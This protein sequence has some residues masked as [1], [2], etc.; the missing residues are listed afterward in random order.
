MQINENLLVGRVNKVTTSIV[1]IESTNENAVQRNLIDGEIFHGTN[2]GEYVIIVSPGAKYLAE[3]T[4]ASIDN[5]EN[6]KVTSH[7]R[8]AVGYDN[9]TNEFFVGKMPTIGGKVYLATSDEIQIFTSRGL[10]IDNNIRQT[11]KPIDKVLYVGN[12]AD[13]IEVSV[14]PSQLFNRHMLLMGATGSGKSTTAVTILSKLE[15]FDSTSRVVIIDPT[16]EY[17]E[18][19]ENQ[20][21]FETFTLGRDAVL[22]Q[23][24]TSPN[25]IADL[26]QAA[27]A[28]QRPLLLSAIESLKIVHEKIGGNPNFAE[29]DI[30][31]DNGLLIKRNHNR[32]EYDYA[33]TKLHNLERDNGTNVKWEFGKLAAQLMEETVKDNKDSGNKVGRFADLDKRLISNIDTVFL[34]IE[35]FIA[36]NDSNQIFDTQS[37]S[38]HTELGHFITNHPEQSVY[39]NL[40]ELRASEIE[41]AFFVDFIGDALFQNQVS[42]SLDSNPTILFL[43]EAHR[44][45]GERIQKKVENEVLE[46]I[47]K[48]AREGR[49]YGLYLM[50]STQSPFD[51]PEGLLGQIGSLMVHRTTSSRDLARIKPYL[52]PDVANKISNLD[53]GQAILS[54]TNLKYPIL[55]RTQMNS[56][57]SH[58]TSSPNFG[59]K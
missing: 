4:D 26:F 5:L 48:I 14:T 22:S 46:S 58:N 50:L 44:Y 17:Q 57:V 37:T 1:T 51:I 24:V 41:L 39:I 30:E 59:N 13:P 43:D 52:S 15:I 31:I 49:K 36:R 45:I 11:E 32:L 21:N 29:L 54:S 23:S 6:R 8:I 12:L 9:T 47:E 18:F 40:S 38:N 28:T 19:A 3:I 25:K 2:V 10:S 27:G 16:G 20:N 34:R 35:R 33:R 55:V 7:A 53:V 56:D 42:K